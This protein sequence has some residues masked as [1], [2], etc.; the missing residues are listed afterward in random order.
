MVKYYK[1][2]MILIA[3]I[4]L[5]CIFS[6]VYLD[7]HYVYTRPPTPQPEIG[8][9]YKLNVHGTIAYLTKEED[10]QL[11]YLFWVGFI[12]IIIGAIITYIW[13]DPFNQNK[14]NLV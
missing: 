7:Y 2:I 14:K 1:K 10:L 5:I 9:I 4:A 11:N 6:G 12:S 8:R 13:C 3:A